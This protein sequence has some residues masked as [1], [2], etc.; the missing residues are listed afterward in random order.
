[1]FK[2]F[3][4]QFKQALVTIIP[5]VILVIAIFFIVGLPLDYLP[6][7][8][9]GTIIL[10]AGLTL[11][12][13]GQNN[14]L[15]YLA[16]NIGRIMVKKRSLAFYALISFSIG[17]SIIVAEPS[18]HVV[19]EQLKS[20]I[21]PL[22]LIVYVS[23]S[24]AIFFTVTLVRILFNIS[25][26]KII[27]GAYSIAVILGIS[28]YLINP[29]FVP[30]AFDMGSVTTGLLS[31]PFIVS[32]G[33]G[34]S[35]ERGDLARE[36]DSF[37]IAG[38]MVLGPLLGMLL[39]GFFRDGN[40]SGSTDNFIDTTTT[41]SQYF[42]A[43]LSSVGLVIGIFVAFFLIFN[44]LYFK[45]D[46]IKTAKVLV[47]FL[48]TY[49]GVV[50]FLTGANGGLVTI[51]YYIGEFFGQTNAFLVLGV[52]IIVGLVVA[53]AEPSVHSLANQIEHV[54]GG[55]IKPSVIFIAISIA[56]G[57]SIGLSYLRAFTGFNLFIL[58]IPVVLILFILTLF[59]PKLYMT[60]SYDSGGSVTGP[61]STAFLMPLSIGI[62]SKVGGN[63]LLDAFGMILIMSM[64]PIII[65]QIFGL[66]VTHK[67]KS[68]IPMF[69]EQDEIIILKGGR[70]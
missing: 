63:I 12:W 10:I 37:G 23:F 50:L 42:I 6:N 69:T 40:I 48:Y 53:L 34:I 68:K 25:Y 45:L 36:E 21:D 27:L 7:F 3:W 47:G 1:M 67:T 24:A 5:T 17:F 11:F 8:M 65:V 57:I 59:T 64:L 33:Y 43:N 62:T 51:G 20:V 38:M 22:I 49:L 55:S 2:A 35:T 66:I 28:L 44:S 4:Q 70:A 39:L 18:L 14:S 29:N 58:I 16:E 60:I 30:V 13:V 52:G 61:M 56:T 41:I 46:K 31:F 15:T 26:R 9:I 19:S 54:S 32:L